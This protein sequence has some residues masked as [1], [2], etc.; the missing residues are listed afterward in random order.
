VVAGATSC[1]A[2]PS[3][4]PLVA[5][6]SY[7]LLVAAI[8]FINEFPDRRGDEAAGKRTLV[9]RLGPDNAKWAWL[10]LVLAAYAW[11]VL[12][13]GRDRLPQGAAA[14]AMT[15]SSPSARPAACW[16]TP[17]R[18]R[19]GPGPQAHHP[20]RPPMACCWRHPG[21]RTLARSAS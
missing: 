15:W 2:A 18:L 10:G 20:R 11:L 16:P 21:L 4:S 3:P 19:T 12:M 7:A 13:V 1:S 14:A 9:V 6:L 8:L 17:T 5:G